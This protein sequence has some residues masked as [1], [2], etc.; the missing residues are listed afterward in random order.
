MS[1]PEGSS[2]IE[3][4]VAG[5]CSMAVGG[6]LLASRWTSS[7]GSGEGGLLPILLGSAFSLFGYFLVTR[8]Q[9][10]P[11]PPPVVEKRRD[12]SE[13]KTA[14]I[15]LI[16]FGAL[17]S[18]CNMPLMIAEHPG[19]HG[20]VSAAGNRELFLIF[21]GGPALVIVGLTLISRASRY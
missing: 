3:A 2:R 5:I 8:G 17:L 16:V 11:K 19:D 15:L 4:M 21:I 9:R 18:L 10:L 1:Q 12:S 14:G 6:L 13:I 7:W 20:M